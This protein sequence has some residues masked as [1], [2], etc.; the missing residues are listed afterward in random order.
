M[1]HSCIGREEQIF[2]NFISTADFADSVIDFICRDGQKEL[3]IPDAWACAFSMR[4]P[5]IPELIHFRQGIYKICLF[6]MYCELPETEIRRKLSHAHEAVSNTEIIFHWL[7]Y[8][9]GDALKLK[10]IELTLRKFPQKYTSFIYGGPCYSIEKL[11]RVLT[12]I[13]THPAFIDKYTNS[14]LKEMEESTYLIRRSV[15]YTIAIE[16]FIATKQ[17][18]RFKTGVMLTADGEFLDDQKFKTNKLDKLISYVVNKY[19]HTQIR[20]YQWSPL[21]PVKDHFEFVSKLSWFKFEGEPLTWDEMILSLNHSIF[22]LL[23]EFLP[24]PSRDLLRELST[25]SDYLLT[26]PECNISNYYHSLTKKEIMTVQIERG[27]PSFTFTGI[28][29]TFTSFNGE[30]LVRKGKAL[31]IK[32]TDDV[33]NSDVFAVK[34]LVKYARRNFAYPGLSNGILENILSFYDGKITQCGLLPTALH[35]IM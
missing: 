6:S 26:F 32:I 33:R 1:E 19:A 27:E 15:K 3:N 17:Q 35:E 18:K 8:S 2:Y 31:D 20:E 5:L 7:E 23:A 16:W 28:E 25:H 29:G 34:D 12:E 30:T 4:D 11:A 13:V 21:P 9:R 24:L 14:M 10:F 22:S